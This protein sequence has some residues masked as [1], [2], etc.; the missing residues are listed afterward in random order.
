MK[1]SLLFLPIVVVV[2]LATGCSNSQ[3]TGASI[4][5]A[6][7]GGIA[8][9]AQTIVSVRL[10]KLKASE[11]YRRH[12]QL[13]QLPQIDAMAEKAGLDPRRDISSLYLVW[14]GKHVLLLAEGAFSA[15]QLE[16]K[17]VAGGAQRVPYKNYTLLTRGN[18]SVVFPG[19]GVAV[20]A[21]TELVQSELDL[22]ASKAGEIPEELKERM[23]EVPSDA[24]IWA[25]SRGGLPAANFPLRADLDSALSNIT[26][27]VTATSFGVHLDSGSHVQARII[28]KSPVGAQRVHD[29]MRGLIG[30]ARLSTKDNELDLLRMWDAVSISK[31]QNVVRVQTDLP[32][33]LSDKL[34]AQVLAL[35]G[36]GGAFL[37]AQ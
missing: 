16:Q 20:A 8:A 37:N 29:A 2:A 34:I 3:Q 22:L 4:D 25:V 33:D 13:L 26:A 31:D 1:Y 27:Y 30:L 24:Q 19:H 32:A 21:A 10:D 23:A 12:E 14:N 15:A 11:L 28:C 35:R 7:R 36:H 17:L 9:D 18:D 6:F 5:D